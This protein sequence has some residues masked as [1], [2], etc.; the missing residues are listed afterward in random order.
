MKPNRFQNLLSRLKTLTAAQRQSVV[1]HLGKYHDNPVLDN[2]EKEMAEKPLC[3][4]C[5][6][7]SIIRYGQAHGRQRYRCKACLR[8][9]MCTNG[10]QFFRLHHHDKWLEYVNNMVQG[11]SLRSCAHQG[12]MALSTAFFWR[13]RFL[14][15]AQETQPQWLEGV[16]E[17]DETY[18]R[19]SQKGQRHLERPA[20]KRGTKA[21][22][23]GL[24]K[25]EWTPVLIAV[26]QI[27]HEMDFI[28]SSVSSRN[29]E[30]TLGTHLSKKCILC[31]DGHLAYRQLCQKNNISHKVSINHKNIEKIFNIQTVNAYHSR[32]KN[33][34]R[35]FHGVATKY[36]GHYLGW[37]RMLE[38]QKYEK[39]NT[40]KL[41]KIQ[42]HWIKT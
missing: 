36:L 30:Q 1:K 35:R 9:F 41:L 6:S 12:D 42:Q 26:D 5:H 27:H 22:T 40:F 24:N 39:L 13:H 15:I 3:P 19:Y 2:L 14:N 18:F 17:A 16:V 20:R 25:K 34:I 38:D 33:W 4:K 31:T 28:L 29:I 21:S 23:R 10:T 37:F 32:L 7:I 11:K 8:T